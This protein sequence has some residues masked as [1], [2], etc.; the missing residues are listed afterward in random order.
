MKV[1]R[2][3]GIGDDGLVFGFVWPVRARGYFFTWHPT[4]DAT[5][6]SV[7]ADT[8]SDD[9]DTCSLDQ[10]EREIRRVWMDEKCKDPYHSLIP[11]DAGEWGRDA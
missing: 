3:Q 7:E 11:R 4:L 1:D 6:A 2:N 5:L 10:V 8:T 9:P